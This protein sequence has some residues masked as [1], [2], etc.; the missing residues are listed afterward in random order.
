VIVLLAPL[1]WWLVITPMKN[2]VGA[3]GERYK[4]LFERSLAGIYRTSIDGRF[5]NCNMAGARLLGYESPEELLRS[6]AVDFS[7]P[8]ERAAFVASMRAERGVVNRE[9]C[10]TRKDGSSIWVLESATF[11]DARDG[12]PAEIE[13]TLI[14]VTDRRRA[15]EELQNAIAAAEDASRS[16]SEFL[17]NMSHEIRTPMN[18]IIGMTELVLDTELNRDQRE[19]LETVRASAESLLAILNDILDFSKVEAGRLELEHVPFAVRDVVAHALRPL[20]SMAEQ[21][22]LELIND[23]AA[24]VPGSVIGDPLRVR[25]VIANLVANA[26]K[27]TEIG[28]VLVQVETEPSEGGWTGLRFSVTDTGIGIA[29]DKLESIFHAFVQADGSTTRRFGG[30]GLGLSISAR[31]VELMGGRIWVES[32]VGAGSTFHF[33]A[34]FPVSQAATPIEQPDPSLAGLRALIVDDNAVNRRIFVEQLSRWQLQP[35]AVESGRVALEALSGAASAGHPFALVLLDANMPDLDGFAVASEVQR[36]PELVDTRLM[37]LTSS[38]RNG[39]AARCQE[40]GI[41]T[42]LTKP[43]RQVELYDAICALFKDV[44]VVESAPVVVRPA[45]AS[46]HVLV[47]EDNLVNQRVVERLLASRGHTVK[48]A[49]NGR[50]AVEKFKAER[51]DIVLMDLQMPEMGG[52]EAT[53]DI[54]DFEAPS[55][56]HV[57]IIAL[58]AHAMTGVRERC[59]AA[60]M[61]GYL[62]KPIDRIQLFDVVESR[63]TP[64]ES[65][66]TAADHAVLL[67]RRALLDRLGGDEEL[68]S[69]V[70]ELFRQDCPATVDR[71]RAAAAA[72]DAT[73]LQGAAHALKGAA[74]NLSAGPLSA[75]ARALETLA[76]SGD[77]SNAAGAVQ[78]VEAEV[79]RLWTS[80]DTQ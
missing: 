8:D 69:E 60:G 22:G 37:M 77:L 35:V 15:Q 57:P 20:A 19:S 26:I 29:P 45:T 68:A 18:G 76:Q 28:H 58:T 63:T 74:G 32:T 55:G 71:I 66:A 73:A 9:S 64:H 79:A 6:N 36:R 53:A 78:Q 27:F 12:A 49:N 47:A 42:Y 13:S 67:D 24:G 75:V 65:S 39:D 48:V 5:L 41:R 51:F 50:E 3:V 54:R 11:I 59:L 4:A 52:F 16:K 17:A 38:G 44:P 31:L 14:D 2:R 7:S 43:V 72:G 56:R 70:I 1:S 40:L 30:T 46:V 61:D 21:K 23:V 62:S 80:L 34:R 25:Q 33:A 10:L